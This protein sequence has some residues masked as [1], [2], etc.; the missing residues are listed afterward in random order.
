MFECP[1]CGKELTFVD[2]YY[3]I[4]VK[5]EKCL[6]SALKDNK[7]DLDFSKEESYQNLL[8]KYK[9]IKDVEKNEEKNFSISMEEYQKVIGSS[10]NNV[11]EI[12]KGH[13]EEEYIDQ[14]DVKKQL[15]DKKIN[16]SVENNFIEDSLPSNT[17]PNQSEYFLE[18]LRYVE[19]SIK[20]GKKFI[21][22]NAPTGI[23][24]SHIAA[25]LCKFLKEGV[26]LTDQ[27]SL[28]LQYVQNFSWMNPVKGM[29]HFSCPDLEWEK[30]ANFGNCEGCKFR[31]DKDHF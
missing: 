29:S 25:T 6:I 1:K 30:T 9:P 28:Q 7:S 11:K 16:L 4:G 17:N 8:K 26:I 19:N 14:E 27:I 31:C 2:N 24:K 18:I 5:C 23:G 22:V 12:E 21:I 13:I 15:Q 10:I 20:N 3:V